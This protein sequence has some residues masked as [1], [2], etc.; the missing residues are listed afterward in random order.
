MILI[1][2]LDARHDKG[3][4]SDEE[5]EAEKRKIQGGAPTD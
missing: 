3:E 2:R 1:S 5:Y 4:I